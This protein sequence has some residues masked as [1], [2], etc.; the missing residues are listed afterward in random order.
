MAVS[1]Y[2]IFFF[3]NKNRL[4]LRWGKL[5][6]IL[7]FFYLLFLNYFSLFTR[8]NL[9]HCPFLYFPTWSMVLL[10]LCD[11]GC[12][13]PE[14][15]CGKTCPATHPG[16]YSQH[17]LNPKINIWVFPL[18]KGEAEGPGE[19]REGWALSRPSSQ[20]NSVHTVP[21]GNPRDPE[22]LR[23]LRPPIL[24]APQIAALLQHPT[25]SHP[26]KERQIILEAGG[27]WWF[28]K[29]EFAQISSGSK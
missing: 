4:V 11:K 26:R 15:P 8:F 18:P 5:A 17:I 10:E 29:G 19:Q 24:V 22:Q 20:G 14:I 16:A 23:W 25:P 7:I 21:P 9:R 12:L 6:R 27:A 28:Y 1:G 13:F 3:F 2:G